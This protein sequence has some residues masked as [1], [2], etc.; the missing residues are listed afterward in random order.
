MNDYLPN[1]FLIFVLILIS[2]MD[3]KFQKL[4]NLIIFPAMLIT[5]LY[6]G[7]TSGYNGVLFS[8]K[9]MVLGIGL[10]ILP[11]AL[12]KMGAG[13]AK[14]MG[15]VGAVLGWKGVLIAALF[16]GIAGGF[17]AVIV[18][19]AGGKFLKGFINRLSLNLKL[20]F[21]TKNLNYLM[22]NERKKGPRLCYGVAIA[23]GTISYILLEW[24]GNNWIVI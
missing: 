5:L 21:M 16:T 24:S 7:I 14:L 20:L 19:F 23:A 17:Y 4:P 11:Y 18:L 12:G 9:G 1:I 6:Y 22:S 15:L 13:D 10:F 3:L 8:L 2:I